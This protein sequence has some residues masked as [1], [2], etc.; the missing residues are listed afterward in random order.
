[1]SKEKRPRQPIDGVHW[2]DRDLV[3]PNDWNPNSQDDGTHEL[4]ARSICEDG[5]TQPIVVTP[6]SSDEG[7]HTIVDGEHRWKASGTKLVQDKWG[8]QVP[9]VVLDKSQT[10]LVS[11]TVRHNRA[12]G[13]HGV[14]EMAT[15]VR[16]ALE[17]GREPDQIR[18]DLGLSEKEFERLLTSEELFLTL[19]AGQDGAMQK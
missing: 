9:V 13:V 17:A 19:F 5:W 7:I 10:D 14:E 18:A 6:P 11:A 4:L 1:M 16:G 15:I 12:R 3:R 8:S 2:V